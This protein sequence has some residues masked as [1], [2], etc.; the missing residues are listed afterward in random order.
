MPNP[1]S[2]QVAPHDKSCDQIPA[3][4]SRADKYHAADAQIPPKKHFT[5]PGQLEP[6]RSEGL[7]RQRPDKYGATQTS[8][9]PD[10]PIWA[11]QNV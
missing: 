11:T 1:A 2:L 6:V 10:P 5:Q 9:S 7:R 3:V 4:L 8:D